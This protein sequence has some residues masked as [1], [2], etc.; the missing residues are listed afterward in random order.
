MEN[1][2][3]PLPIAPPVS[4]AET[5][6]N[7]SRQFAQT[8]Y[9]NFFNFPIMRAKMALEAVSTTD[10]LMAGQQRALTLFHAA[11]RRVPA[12]RDF[13]KK[14]KIKPE[15]I[16][17]FNDYKKIPWIDKKN[18]LELYSLEELSWDGILT[19]N[20]MISLSSGSS[21]TPFYWPRGILLEL[22]ATYIH[23][24]FLRHI[25]RC[26]RYRTLFINAFSMGMYV[27]GPLTLNA[28]LRVAQKGYPITIITPGLEIRDAI[29]AIKDLVPEFEQIVLAG[30]P[31][32]V[33]DIIDEG[34]RQGMDWKKKRV[35]FL[36]AGEGFNESWRDYVATLVNQKET[37]YNDFINIY[38][39]ADAGLIGHE[40]PTSITLRR[41]AAQQPTA[42]TDLV[43]NKNNDRLPTF[44]QYYPTSKYFE[45]LDNELIITA[46]AGVP[47]VR[48]NIHDFGGVFTLSETLNRLGMTLMDFQ[49]EF[50]MHHA[51]TQPW[52]L[53]FVYLYGKSDQTVTLYGLNIYP[54]NIKSALE[55]KSI[56]EQVTGRFTMSTEYKRRSRNQYLLINIELSQGVYENRKLSKKINETIVKK[57]RLINFEYN[58]LYISVGSR[59]S[60]PVVKLY[61]YQDNETIKRGIKHSWVKK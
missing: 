42:I 55:D 2:P 20:Q 27:A 37:L 15:S 10:W 54:E 36:L 17:T 52:H 7:L 18:Y 3:F 51:T 38:G 4:T 60:R 12:Y 13:L 26:D 8:L 19:S 41:L 28:L 9:S 48:Y 35:R 61:S 49:K 32:F 14:N 5:S 56:R 46:S 30:Y 33:K 22:E 29:R 25:F 44:V 45:A 59:K 31:P 40:T 6:A 58:K 23:E 24:I 1:E 16:Q 39:T 53:P 21:G 43:I 34:Q 57:L 11:A 50:G 47:L